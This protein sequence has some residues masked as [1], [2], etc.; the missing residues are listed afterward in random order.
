MLCFAVMLCTPHS[1]LACGTCHAMA[2]H[3]PLACRVK[4]DILSKGVKA[5]YLIDSS[6]APFFSGLAVSGSTSTSS[7]AFIRA[8]L[9][10]P[11]EQ[12]PKISPPFAESTKGFVTTDPLKPIIVKLST[13]VLVSSKAAMHAVRDA[14]QSCGCTNGPW[15]LKTRCAAQGPTATVPNIALRFDYSQTGVDVNGVAVT[16]FVSVYFTDYVGSYPA[17][18]PPTST[19]S[20][21]VSASI[22]VHQTL[23]KPLKAY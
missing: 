8:M 17:G 12:L 9:L 6:M 21:A 7:F 18:L 20:F 19:G 5:S 1:V 13:K 3:P 16:P 22:N 15:D 4:R 10:F 14:L 23:G 11:Q 2:E